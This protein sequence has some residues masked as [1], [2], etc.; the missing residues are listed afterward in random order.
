MV[1]IGNLTSG[2][3]FGAGCLFAEHIDSNWVQSE[4]EDTSTELSRS[5]PKGGRVLKAPF[6]NCFSKK[7]SKFK[8]AS[9]S[10]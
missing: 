2:I 4:R 5:S 6:E 1:G 7:A 9:T 10:D 3:L 8:V